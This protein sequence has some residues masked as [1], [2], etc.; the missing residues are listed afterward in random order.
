MYKLTSIFF[1]IA[2]LVGA[3]VSAQVQDPGRP[4]FYVKKGLCGFSSEKEGLYGSSL[5]IGCRMPDIK[6]IVPYIIEVDVLHQRDRDQNN[7]AAFAKVAF[8]KHLPSMMNNFY[9]GA[10]VSI[11]AHEKDYT[12]PFSKDDIGDTSDIEDFYKN[13]MENFLKGRKDLIGVKNDR[14]KKKSQGGIFAEMLLG[15]EWT[16]FPSKEVKTVG[17][18]EKSRV[19]VPMRMFI[20]AS[21]HQPAFVI[22]RNVS[23]RPHLQI[24][25]GVGF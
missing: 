15:F 5:G 13:G 11:G 4:E 7:R 19:N 23:Y 25:V 12:I 17:Q 6:G 16:I 2:L 3:T 20:E 9:A 24:D 18:E 14:W 8:Y 10:G 22:Q 21:L 1:G